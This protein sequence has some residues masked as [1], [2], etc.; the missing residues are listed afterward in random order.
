MRDG[1]V[2][3]S[4]VHHGRAADFQGIAHHLGCKSNSGR[5]L[6]GHAQVTGDTSLSN[7]NWCRAPVNTATYA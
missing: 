3:L 4:N 6:I 7:T 2:N 5:L 1:T